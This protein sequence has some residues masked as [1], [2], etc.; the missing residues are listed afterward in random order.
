MSDHAAAQFKEEARLVQEAVSRSTATARQLAA[1]GTSASP[2]VLEA[3]AGLLDSQSTLLQIMAQL[4]TETAPEAPEHGPLADGHV[5]S[6]VRRFR[7]MAAS[8]DRREHHVGP[9]LFHNVDTVDGREEEHY[10]TAQDARMTAA[11]LETLV[12]LVDGSDTEEATGELAVELRER[13]QQAGQEKDYPLQVL[14]QTTAAQLGQQ[15]GL[16]RS[17]ARALDNCL[18]VTP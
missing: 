4:A 8:Q 18:G 3:M 15:T 2:E 6:L 10:L 16:L 17:M 14:L 1:A 5:G 9:R 7:G 12:A 13:A 11:A